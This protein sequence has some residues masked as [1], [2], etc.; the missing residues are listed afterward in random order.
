MADVHTSWTA[1]PL[2]GLQ[3]LPHQRLR[4]QL[5]AASAAAAGHVLPLQ[6]HC[7]LPTM[8]PD[9]KQLHAS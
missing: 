3:W 2:V 5:P 8:T 4:F 1:A 9:C 7:C 6:L